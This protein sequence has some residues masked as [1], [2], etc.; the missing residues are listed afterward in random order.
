[1]GAGSIP[2]LVSVATCET[3]SGAGVTFHEEHTAPKDTPLLD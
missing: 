2:L 3:C 1:M